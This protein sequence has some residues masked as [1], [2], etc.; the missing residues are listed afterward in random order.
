MRYFTL[1]VVMLSILS[2][3]SCVPGL[4]KAI[5]GKWQ[6]VDG[7][8]T[9]EFIRGGTVTLLD[10]KMSVSGTYEF[11]DKNRVKIEMGGL[12]SLMGAQVCTVSVTGDHMLLVMP[13]G[14]KTTYRRVR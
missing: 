9:I 1:V 10:G 12:F 7:T 13:D 4:H 8:E 5:I 2:L 6:E 14:D 11:V 3:A